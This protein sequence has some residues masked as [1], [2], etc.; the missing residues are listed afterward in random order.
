[1]SS[2][3]TFG[4]RTHQTGF[5]SPTAET[6]DPTGFINWLDKKVEPQQPAAGEREE[7]A[8]GEKSAFGEESVFDGSDAGDLIVTP[9]GGDEPP[10]L[11]PVLRDTDDG[12]QVIDIGATVDQFVAPVATAGPTA[13]IGGDN[14]EDLMDYLNRDGESWSWVH[15]NGVDVKVSFPEWLID[16]R[17]EMV[18][19]LIAPEE[20]GFT[21]FEPFSDTQKGNAIK[22]LDHWAEL[23]GL[24]FTVVEPGTDADIYFIGREFHS[25]SKAAATSSGVDLADGSLIKFDTEGGSWSSMNPGTNGYRTLLHEIGHSIGLDHPGD[26]DAADE[27]EYETHAEYV[28][29][30]TMYSV[31][32]YFDSDNTGGS[33]GRSDMVTART[34][35]IWVAQK[36][37]GANWST[38]DGNS[39]YGNI[40]TPDTAGTVY[41]IF[42]S[43]EGGPHLTIWDAGGD[44]DWLD[45]SA[46][47]AGMTLNLNPGSFSSTNGETNNLSLAYAPVEEIPEGK[48]ILIENAKGG[49]GNDLLIGNEAGN[50]LEGKDGNDIIAGY[51]GDDELF[52]GDGDDTL[53]GGFGTDYLNGGEGTDLADFTHSSV[54]W[55]ID[56]SGF[57]FGWASNDFG[58]EQ[59]VS[60]EEINGS[61]GDD[62][63]IGSDGANYLFG[64]AGN[65]TLEGG[66][67]NDTLSGGAGNDRIIGGLGV[68]MFY[69]GSG[70]DTLDYMAASGHWDIDMLLGTATSTLGDDDTFSQFE[71]IQA[72]SGSDHIYGMMTGEQIFA[73]GGSDVVHGRSGDDY[74]NGEAGNDI[75]SGGIGND[76]IVGGAGTDTARYADATSGVTV[77]LQIAGQ[78][79]TGGAGEDLLLEIENIAGSDHDDFLKGNGSA[80]YLT[81]YDGGDLLLGRAGNDT[82]AG[83]EGDD[84]LE[85]GDGDD[86]LIGGN[87]RDAASYYFASAPVFVY[88]GAAGAHNTQGAGSDTYIGIEDIV[89]SFFSDTLYGDDANNRIFAGDGDDVLVGGAGSDDLYGGLGNDILIGGASNDYINGGGGT[90]WVRYDG[91][92]GDLTVDLADKTEQWTG[93]GTD[94]IVYVENLQGSYGDDDLRGDG[95]NNHIKGMA[96]DDTLYGGQGEDTLEGGTGDDVIYAG[97]DHPSDPPGGY[98]PLA[99]PFEPSR[100]AI[101]GLQAGGFTGLI[102]DEDYFVTGKLAGGSE[103][104]SG[105]GHLPAGGKTTL[106][107]SAP[108]VLVFSGSWGND[109]VFDF[110][111]GGDK[112]DFGNAA[113]VD[114]LADLSINNVGAGVMISHG[115]NSVLLHDLE[116]ADLSDSDF[117]F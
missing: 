54:D 79:D 29:D 63:I 85:G 18:Q 110:T 23:T 68:N 62:H 17:P 45:F 44:A 24:T 72:G 5:G 94:K 39:T 37:Y 102:D 108:D 9:K 116:Q 26:Y 69:G 74:L 27:P 25:D 42:P 106:P 51:D 117:W 66:L 86:Q 2:K 4:P 64:S 52:G 15:G 53:Q 20:P 47:T 87:G 6:F 41:Q 50:I 101:G 48:N 91:A 16:L 109:E 84:V 112:L 67:G 14:L 103:T 80:N 111:P 56:L 12:R 28:Q 113:G 21:V 34:H 31:M 59:L 38:R 35:D 83:G 65:D 89:G 13:N 49:Y 96:G 97:L 10:D 88:L 19:E 105:S 40:A 8:F 1:M 114:E 22:A 55:V 11:A 100:G 36:L 78:Q 115:V 77:D 93:A 57:V 73:G 70:F 95:G 33:P 75:L 7:N 90:D 71:R 81:G 92:A 58:S 82:L 43:L 46:D 98:V 61:Q 30:S 107:G 76:I 32:S 3:H 99:E 60:I 104:R